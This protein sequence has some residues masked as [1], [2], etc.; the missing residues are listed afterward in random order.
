VSRKPFSELLLNTPMCDWVTL[1]S[2]HI[3]AFDGLMSDPESAKEVRRLNYVGRQEGKLFVGSGEQDGYFHK[4]LQVSGRDSNLWIDSLAYLED[5][6]CTHL[7]IQTT[8]EW[9]NSDI[10]AIAERLRD[11][12]LVDYRTSREGDTVY[13][14]SR[15][16]DKFIRIYQKTADIV[17]F[18][19]AYKKPYARV[20]FQQFQVIN[21]KALLSCEDV[22]SERE[23]L[24][25]DW[26]SWELWKLQDGVLNSIFSDCL[27]S[28]PIRP[29]K[30]VP[31]PENNTE[32]W[33]RKIVAPALQKYVN[34]HE[35]DP[36]LV[37]HLVRILGA[38]NEL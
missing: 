14:Y 15:L 24:M 21:S 32:R 17:R 27:G 23:R 13:I 2:W 10:F 9:E 25:R 12:F 1:T 3:D 38:S 8:C 5:V 22:A 35:A 19:V 37:H 29:P 7:D 28:N 33:L 36:Y 6:E 30:F 4:M 18:E 26:L 34:S 31:A 11:R 20:M 16:S